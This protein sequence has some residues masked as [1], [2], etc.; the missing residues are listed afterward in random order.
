M[1]KVID[2]PTSFSWFVFV[3]KVPAGGI[4]VTLKGQRFVKNVQ[5]LVER[6]QLFY[7]FTF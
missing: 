1:Q 2:S 5:V 3:L 4:S 6:E 7:F